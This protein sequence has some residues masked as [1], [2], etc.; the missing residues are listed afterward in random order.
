MHF[1]FGSKLAASCQQTGSKLA[2]NWQQAVFQDTAP[3]IPLSNWRSFCQP[4][5]QEDAWPNSL[6]Q[7]RRQ[8]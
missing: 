7:A 4:S 3:D 8:T 6:K 2:A 5:Q 1:Q